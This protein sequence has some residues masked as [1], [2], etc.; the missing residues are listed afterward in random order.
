[1]AAP[2]LFIDTPCHENWQNMTPTEQ[3]RFC[4]VCTKEVIDFTGMTDAELL[5]YF[6]THRSKN[7]CGRL[8]E[9]QL[10]RPLA[11]RPPEKKR[12]YW[13]YAMVFLA[14]FSRA[15]SAKAQAKPGTELA[16]LKN[17]NPEKDYEFNSGITINNGGVIRGKVSDSRG[18]AVPFAMIKIIGTKTG[19]TADANGVFT[20]RVHTGQK[21]SVSSAGYFEKIVQPQENTLMNIILET[22]PRF[23]GTNEI[24][25]VTAGGIGFSDGYNGP[26]DRDRSKH[27]AIFSVKDSINHKPIPGARL[28]M[29]KVGTSV[30]D[31]L[32][33]GKNGSVKIKRIGK[34]V[35]YDIRVTA[36]GF[37][38]NEF[39]LSGTEFEK[40]KENW[41]V[42]L[43]P[44]PPPPATERK[45]TKI[46]LG[47]V[48]MAKDIPPALIM[49]DGKKGD[50]SVLLNGDNI[51]SVKVIT[52]PR[53][54]ALFGKDGA[55]GVMIITTNETQNQSKASTTNETILSSPTPPEEMIKL[56]SI[57]IYPN[58]V[59]RDAFL[60]IQ[61]QLPAIE[62]YELK[63]M[64]S[65]GDILHSR[66]VN[67]TQKSAVLML[68]TESS[69][70]AG[71]YYVIISDEKGALIAKHNF[72][73]Q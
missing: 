46:N 52:G 37:Q 14:L 32:I 4:K 2:H 44:V 36:E 61:L 9:Y 39:T 30:P 18:N 55:N 63:I 42:F 59:P 25:V 71:L 64:N 35:V 73:V 54:V 3:G 20:I 57:T 21:L 48:S 65:N 8:T 41:D 12:W 34:E 17:L 62:K 28:I 19:L 40:R 51:A 56:S 15:G 26:Y 72:I 45:P 31:T 70:A 49:V 53:A 68:K 1:M 50:K 69:W 43:S 6:T 38:P 11:P 7:V 29:Q 67:A 22:D 27:V 23:S 5:H 60:R 47:G 10:N 33:A 66:P 13:T 24:I 58:P 16:P